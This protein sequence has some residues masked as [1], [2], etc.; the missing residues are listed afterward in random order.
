M[1][2]EVITVAAVHNEG[3]GSIALFIVNRHLDE[4]VTFSIELQ[5]FNPLSVL[6]HQVIDARNVTLT[7]TDSEPDRVTPA[8]GETLSVSQQQLQL[9]LAPLSYHFI[10][11]KE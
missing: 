5:Q 10:L 9:T 3:K 2:Y 11:L 8:T 4:E 6:A 7:N 1:L